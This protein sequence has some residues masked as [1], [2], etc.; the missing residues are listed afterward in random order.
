MTFWGARGEPG[1]WPN[2]GF[3]GGPGKVLF[4]DDFWSFW[5]VIGLVDFEKKIF[6]FALIILGGPERGTGRRVP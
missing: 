4:F 2:L 1:K 3:F 5:G 6:R